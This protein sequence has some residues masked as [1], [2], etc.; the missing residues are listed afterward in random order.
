MNPSLVVLGH[1]TLDLIRRAAD[2][3]VIRRLGGA[4]SFCARVAERQGETVG[5]VTAAPADLDV[6][7][8]LEGHAHIE[9]ALRACAQATTF[10]LDYSVS[11]RAL[12]LLAK[13]DELQPSMLPAAWA[14]AKT[15]FIGPVANECTPALAHALP[16][17]FVGVG[18]QGVMREVAHDGAIRPAWPHAWLADWPPAAKVAVLSDEDHP[19]AAAVAKAVASKGAVV[20][21]THGS[22]GATLFL[23]TPTGVDSTLS[24]PAR[25]AVEV[26][27]TGAGDTF[28]IVLTLGLAAGKPV[29]AAA[30]SAAE[31]AAR[32]VEGVGLGRL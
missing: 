21:L 30:Q 27:P 4:A 18:L 11:P 9:V 10:S 6:L 17:A 20:A 28:A 29:S 15:A 24:V 3:T 23:P 7:A 19:E 14:S 1:V 2:A 26:D 32:V 25:P 13:A 22:R 5:V 12:R 16:H 31:A 8:E